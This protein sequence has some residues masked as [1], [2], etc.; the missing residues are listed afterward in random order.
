MIDFFG[1]RRPSQEPPPEGF[2]IDEDFPKRLGMDTLSDETLNKII[3]NESRSASEKTEQ[4]WAATQEAFIRRGATSQQAAE[5]IM[6]H[7]KYGLNTVVTR[8]GAL[9]TWPK[10]S[11][12]ESKALVQ[13]I[14]QSEPDLDPAIQAYLQQHLNG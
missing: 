13:R 5:Q 12:P 8:D 11:T 4:G 14:L 3:L 7:R 10:R 1:G 9:G 2:Q 6:L